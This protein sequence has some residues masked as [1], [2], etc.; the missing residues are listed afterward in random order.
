MHN[1]GWKKLPVILKIIW[2]YLAITTLSSLLG[3]F[4]APIKQ[5]DFLGYQLHGLWAANV[6]F[7]FNI[8]IPVLLL[9]AMFARRK[10]AW[11]LGLLFFIFVCADSLF[12]IREAPEMAKAVMA[13]MPPE[14]LDK[15]PFDPM[16]M[17]IR[18]ARIELVFIAIMNLFFAV[19][20]FVKRKYFTQQVV[21]VKVETK[22]ENKED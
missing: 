2:I 9:I 22:E 4:Q 16:A 14:L 17:I 6:M 7:I 1:Y 20:F 5:V 19:M 18:I 12:S 3:L 21:E 10:S 15:V 13:Q 11:L 8:I